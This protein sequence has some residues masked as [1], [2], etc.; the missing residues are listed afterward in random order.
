MTIEEDYSGCF[1]GA[2]KCSES[3]CECLDRSAD[4]VHALLPIIAAEL[5]GVA[6]SVIAK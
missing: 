6:R 5:A 1:S 3:A 2:E 4:A